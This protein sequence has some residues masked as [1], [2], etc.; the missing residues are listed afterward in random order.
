MW[1]TTGAPTPVS[2]R[3]FSFYHCSG[4]VYR[5]MATCLEGGKFR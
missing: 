2:Y 4:E 5:C 3:Y 1:Y